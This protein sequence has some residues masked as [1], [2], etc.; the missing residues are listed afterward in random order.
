[1]N[2]RFVALIALVSLACLASSGG[3]QL[4]NT[5]CHAA[6]NWHLRE[7]LRYSERDTQDY[8]LGAAEAASLM[9]TSSGASCT[10]WQNDAQ[11]PGYDSVKSTM[12]ARIAE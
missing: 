7:A 12:G 2:L 10:G 5:E 1:M 9:E 11:G 8:H 6:K 3:A 4:S